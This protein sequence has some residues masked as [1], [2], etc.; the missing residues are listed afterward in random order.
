MGYLLVLVTNQSGS[1][2]DIFRKISFATDRMDG[3]VISG[4]RGLDLDG[5]Y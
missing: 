1:H 5:I 3:L 4:H 2:M